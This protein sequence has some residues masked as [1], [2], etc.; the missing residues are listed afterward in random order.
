LILL[1]K[2]FFSEL[3]K[4]VFECEFCGT[5]LTRNY[6]L[7]R[8]KSKCK[9]AP[10]IPSASTTVTFLEPKSTESS[11]EVEQNATLVEKKAVVEFS[12]PETPP[13]DAA[14]L[15]D[16]SPLIG[17]QPLQLF[18]LETPASITREDTEEILSDTTDIVDL[19]EEASES[20]KSPFS[21][22]DVKEQQETAVEAV[23]S[24]SERFNSVPPN[25]VIVG[26]V[27]F[28]QHV[29]A[30]VQPAT[31]D[32]D[33]LNV[34]QIRSKFCNGTP[35]KPVVLRQGADKLPGVEIP[36]DERLTSFRRVTEGI[37][38]NVKINVC[39]SSIQEN[40]DSFTLRKFLDHSEDRSLAPEYH[41]M[42]VI[43]LNVDSYS[44]MVS[45]F[46]LPNLVRDISF[47]H[48]MKAS[49]SPNNQ[50]AFDFTSG[51]SDYLLMAEAG[52]QTNWHQD[53]SGTSVFYVLAKGKKHFFVV[54]P[55]EE[56]NTFR[57]LASES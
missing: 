21:V 42:N 53:F 24:Y 31:N 14:T 52:A 56:K 8:H 48:R 41:P 25:G 32:F 12:I 27:E 7:I 17:D 37:P 26:S 33:V 47:G 6:D 36:P 11:D 4:G 28:Q 40:E 5:N 22:I 43:D 23:A 51:I 13:R 44:G 54:E 38:R 16:E 57:R 39:F 50:A 15:E 9:L 55:T 18:Q 20:E 35:S 49:L 3:Q 1:D 45:Q 30:T 46:S 10:A 34:N 29:F 19:G 2:E